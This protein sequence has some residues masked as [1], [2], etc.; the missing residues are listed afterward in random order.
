MPAATHVLES[1]PRT[2][3]CGLRKFYYEMCLSHDTRALGSLQQ[4]WC[5]LYN[6]VSKELRASPVSGYTLLLR[7]PPFSPLKEFSPAPQ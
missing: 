2:V 1:R 5:S 7:L 3:F 4:G 6:T